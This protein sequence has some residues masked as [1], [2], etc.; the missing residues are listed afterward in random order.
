MPFLLYICYGD[1]YDLAMH[2]EEREALSRVFGINRRIDISTGFKEGDSVRVIS[3][4]MMG[5]ESII[6]N[7]NKGRH[8][9]VISVEMFG[10][11]VLVSVGLEVMEKI[12]NRHI[13][14]I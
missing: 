13:L 10:M 5:Q 14:P 12:N 11:V 3:G 8:G 6:L 2:E 1:R 9:A 7:I 4:L